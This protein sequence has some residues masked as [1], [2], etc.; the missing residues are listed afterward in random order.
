LIEG[1]LQQ[2]HFRGEQIQRRDG[3]V[4]HCDWPTLIFICRW[5]WFAERLGNC[6]DSSGVIQ[7]V[8]SSASDRIYGCEVTAV[9]GIVIIAGKFFGQGTF[10]SP[11]LR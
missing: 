5:R 1:M 11:F 10:G 4:W 6:A 2:A 7:P 9:C 8:R 3:F